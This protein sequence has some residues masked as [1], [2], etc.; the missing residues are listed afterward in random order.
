[1]ESI[2]GLICRE[3]HTIDDYLDEKVCFTVSDEVWRVLETNVLANV[4]AE[5]YDRVAGYIRGH[6]ITD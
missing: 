2:N 5:V 1:M 4:D 6:E 3:E